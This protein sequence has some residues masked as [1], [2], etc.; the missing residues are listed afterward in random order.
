M[1][2]R[3]GSAA[4]LLV[5]VHRTPTRPQG[6]RLL[7]RHL[8]ITNRCAAQRAPGRCIFLKNIQ[9]LMNRSLR[10]RVGRSSLLV[11]TCSTTDWLTT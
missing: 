4:T 3:D 7:L 9:W 6:R 2:P 1:V 8:T 5:E 10:V 11:D